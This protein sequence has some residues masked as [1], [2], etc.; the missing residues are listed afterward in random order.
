MPI[1]EFEQLTPREHILMEHDSEE[2]RLGR[3]HAVRMKELDLALA[4]EKNQSEVAL[5]T[6]EAKWSSWLRLP[7]TL[8]KLP[9]YVLLAVGYIISVVTKQKAPP[10]FWKLINK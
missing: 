1:Q 7:G 10:E 4:R 9:V 8:I 3:E 6:L 2:A 5:R